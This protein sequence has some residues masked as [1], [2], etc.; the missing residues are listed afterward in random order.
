MEWI[1]YKH[2]SPSGKVYIGQTKNGK[3]RW[4]GGKSAYHNGK[5]LVHAIEK[6]GW[7]NFTHEILEEHIPTQNEANLREIYWIQYYNSYANGYNM[8]K[9]GHHIS[10]KA[11]IANS[12]QII[13]LDDDFNIIN[14]FESI[15]SA[16]QHVNVSPQGIGQC[17]IGKS[18]KAAGYYWALKSDYPELKN[19]KISKYNNAIWC[20][21]LEQAFD[22]TK[23]AALYVNADY[24][25]INR[26]LKSKTNLCKGYH[27]CVY[28]QKHTYIPPAYSREYNGGKSRQRKIICV[29]SKEIF[30]SITEASNKYGISTQN[31][32]QNC[33]KNHRTAKGLHF[34]YLDEYNDNWKPAECY[35]TEKR[36]K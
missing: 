30:N 12:K 34:A 22:N 4:K 26:A 10:K 2:T 9:G 29:E 3:Y 36:K 25:C 28:S 16:A 13:Q 31:L 20:Y 15:V 23:E 33:C 18:C 24:S 17:T 19:I 6:Y 1:I 27:W 8:T 32:S 11:K 21:E 5:K 7:D 35:T 14:E